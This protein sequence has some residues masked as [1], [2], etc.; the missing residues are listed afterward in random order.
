[1]HDMPSTLPE[2]RKYRTRL[3]LLWFCIFRLVM[4][5]VVHWL[6]NH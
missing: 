1:M 3:Q 2:D 5:L 4:Q 6:D